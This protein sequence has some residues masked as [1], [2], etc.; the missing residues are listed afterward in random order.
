[1][2]L[3]SVSLQGIYE[4]SIHHRLVEVD[5]GYSAFYTVVFVMLNTQFRDSIHLCTVPEKTAFSVIVLSSFC[6]A[7]DFNSFA[8][9]LMSCPI[10]IV[11]D[12]VAYV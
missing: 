8:Q 12:G 9:L 1:M 5:K 2:C 4:A 11:F 10:V 7:C 6:R 3:L